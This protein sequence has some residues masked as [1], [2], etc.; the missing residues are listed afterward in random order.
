MPEPTGIS[1]KGTTLGVKET[2]SA[3][4]FTIIGAVQEVPDVGGKP[5]KIEVTTLDDSMKRYI[6]GLVDPGDLAFKLLYDNSSE[7]SNFRIAKS[8]EGQILPYEVTYPD[9]T[10]HDFTAA[11]YASMDSAKQG[12]PLTFTMT[13]MLNSSITITNPV[14]G[15]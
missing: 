8:V 7:A 3:P 2:T 9:G 11:S 12:D 1:S 15:S 10:K 13:L 14:S 6:P 5:D 4:S